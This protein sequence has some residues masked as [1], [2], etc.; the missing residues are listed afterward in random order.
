MTRTTVLRRIILPQAVRV[1]LPPLANSF[2]GLVKDTS[3]AASI[4]IVEMFEV[5][6]QIAAQNYQPLVMYCLVAALYAVVCTALSWLQGYLEKVTS[7]YVTT[8]N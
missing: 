4:T 3:L 2:I 5:S 1:S 7:R 6:Q 8:S